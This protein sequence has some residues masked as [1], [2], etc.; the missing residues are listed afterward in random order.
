M[1]Q[2]SPSP[3]VVAVL[4]KGVTD[5]RD[6]LV[7]LLDANN[8][9]LRAFDAMRDKVDTMEQFVSALDILHPVSPT[10]QTMTFAAP[11]APDP[12]AFSVSSQQTVP[13]D[14]NVV[15][16]DPAPQAAQSAAQQ[17]A[18]SLGIAPVDDINSIN[19]GIV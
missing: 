3:A 17:I 12:F 19:R 10:I 8:G 18:S 9:D 7:A 4:W 2:P 1:V 5:A 16:G 14:P 11:P 6:Q 15:V 13:A